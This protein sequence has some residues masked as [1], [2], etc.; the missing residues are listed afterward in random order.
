MPFDRAATQVPTSIGSI[1]IQLSDHNSTYTDDDGNVV[2]TPPVCTF[3]IE[4]LDQNGERME[5]VRGPLFEKITPESQQW[6]LASIIGL[7]A[8]AEAEILGVPD[9]GG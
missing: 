4:V 5:P 1:V 7:R 3:V 9:G 2:P 6:I 8:Q